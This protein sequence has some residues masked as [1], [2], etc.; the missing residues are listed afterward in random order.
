MILNRNNSYIMFLFFLLNFLIS[1]ANSENPNL[2]INDGQ[3]EGTI[4]RTKGGRAFSAFLGIPYAEPP[5]G[6]L[7]FKAPVPIKPW[8]GILQATKSH[9]FCPQEDYFSAKIIGEENC[10]FLNVYTPRL[11]HESK[12]LLPVLVYIHGGAFIFGA[13]TNENYGPE[14]LLDKDLILVTPNYRLGALG[15]LSTNDDVSPGNYG[16]KDQSLAL[17]WVNKNIKHFGGDPDSVT[18]GGVSAG[19]A[20]SHY[21]LLSPLN[22]GLFKGVISQSGISLCNWAFNPEEENIKMLKH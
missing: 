7:R 20:S 5:M 18:V 4:M 9:P 16:L 2:I 22:T 19:G 13:A 14:Y 6:E 17:K 11:P 12:E 21:Q 15:F 8:E 3:L 1:T 10:L